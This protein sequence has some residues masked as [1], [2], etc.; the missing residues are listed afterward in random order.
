MRLITLILIFAALTTACGAKPSDL[1][2]PDGWTA[3]SSG[4]DIVY[5]AAI[6]CRSPDGTQIQIYD[7]RGNPR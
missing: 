5:Q 6:E 4:Y 2:C 3:L 1:T 7:F